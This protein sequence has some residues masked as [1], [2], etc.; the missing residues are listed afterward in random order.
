MSVFDDSGAA[1]GDSVLAV[2]SVRA[3]TE[4]G[5]FHEF[6]TANRGEIIARTRAKVALRSAPRPTQRE[7]ETGVPLFLDQLVAVLGGGRSRPAEDMRGHRRDSG[8]SRWPSARTGIHDLAGRSWLRG[9]VPGLDGAGAG[10]RCGHHHGGVSYPQPVSRRRHRRGGDGVHALARAGHHRR[11]D[12]ALGRAR[13]RAAKPPVRSQRRV[14][15]DQERHRRDRR[16]RQRPGQPQPR[17]H[18]SLIHRS[19]VE[20]RLES[21]IEYRERV[22]VAE[23]IEE[24]EVDGSLEAAARN[25]A[26]T[27]T[28]GRSGRGG[29]RSI[30]RSWPARSPT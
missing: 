19:L 11:R 23:L 22:S 9:R 27:V 1:R 8:H 4:S 12:R 17:T 7:L 20:V 29:A 14:R 26:L 5:M 2:P 18:G 10:D 30:A 21:G 13:A 3:S 6:V 28:H 15:A 25:Q 24:A 16:Q